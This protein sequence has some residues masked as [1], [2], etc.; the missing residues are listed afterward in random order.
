V[1]EFCDT[2]GVASGTGRSGKARAPESAEGLGSGGFRLTDN[3]AGHLMDFYAMS[4]L[5]LFATA[6][7]ER[8]E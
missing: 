3:G 8:K 2:F 5:E 6:A 1:P 7:S 4:P